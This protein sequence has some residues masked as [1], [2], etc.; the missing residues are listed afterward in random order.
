MLCQ[1]GY[2]DQRQR[3]QTED[4]RK[5]PEKDVNTLYCSHVIGAKSWSRMGCVRITVGGA[6]KG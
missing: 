6:L 3:K 4:E 1:K 5:E 2:L